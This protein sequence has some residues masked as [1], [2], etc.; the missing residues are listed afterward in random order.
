MIPPHQR[1][2]IAYPQPYYQEMITALAFSEG[3][4]KSKIAGDLLKKKIDSLDPHKRAFLED[5]YK[6][7]TPEQRKNP[8]KNED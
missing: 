5:V 1:R 2:I 4:T 8:G 3:T 7:M 6:R